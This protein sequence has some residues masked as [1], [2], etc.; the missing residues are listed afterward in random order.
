MILSPAMRSAAGFARLVFLLA[1][2]GGMLRA[3]AAAAPRPKRVLAL[4]DFGKDSPAN[5][6]W[7][8]TIRETLAAA[9]TD[10]AEY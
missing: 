4:F 9:G 7:D 3:D 2:A 10:V 1:T 8:R 6:I 5:V